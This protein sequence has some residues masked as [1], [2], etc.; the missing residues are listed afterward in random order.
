MSSTY[1]H[2]TNPAEQKRLSVMNSFLNDRSLQQ[3]ALRGG[4]R[5]LDLGAGLGQF[6]RAMA[7]GSGVEV[8]GIERS[9]EQLG[10]AQRIASLEGESHLVD[11]R[12]GDVL[13][14]DLKP[15]EWGSFDVVHTRFVLE[16]VSNPV[17]V[18]Q[19]MVRAAKPGGRIVLED[20]DHAL[21]RLWPE[22]PGFQS[23]WDAYMNSYEAIGNDPNIGRKLVEL[24]HKG[25]ARPRANSWI[26]FGSCSGD[27]MF[28][29]VVEN[30]IGVLQTASEAITTG[31]VSADRF[32]SVVTSLR[33]WGMR[34][35]A[36][37]WYP[38]AWA[39]GTK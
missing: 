34:P 2:G 30:L 3:L 25:G 19:S 13:A 29:T 11:F 38:M 27:P 10:E 18:V 36:A 21:M 20:D 22:L 5:I 6:S 14:L 4:E 1:I 33:E 39:E 32:E 37:L 12:R 9:E 31:S 28:T 35:D 17:A 15:Q 26:F 8:V 7:R 23:L 16:H 24:L